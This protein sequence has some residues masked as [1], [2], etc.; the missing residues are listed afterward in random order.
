MSKFP[1]ARLPVGATPENWPDLIGGSVES[2]R[3]WLDLVWNRAELAESVALASPTLAG[4][5]QRILRGETA[6]P[7]AVRKATLSM[8]RYLLRE[9]GR[10]TPF[11]LF[12]GVAE[13]RFGQGAAVRWSDRH[14]LIVR[15]DGEWLASVIT[16][17]EGCP[18]LLVRL[19]VVANSLNQV[20]FD[21]LCLRRGQGHV[22]VPYTV[23]VRSALEAARSPI[24]AGALADVLA[25]QFVSVPRASVTSMI[26]CLVTEGFLVTCL[27]APSVIVNPL[28]YLL[29]RL[30]AVGADQVSAV[31]STLSGLHAIHSQVAMHNELDGASSRLVRAPLAVRMRDQA[32]TLRGP[33]ASDLRLDADLT[34]PESVG[35]EMEKAASVL[36]RL[37]A[38]PAGHE[39]WRD[40]LAAFLDRYGVGTLVPLT[41]LVHPDLGL[42]L[43]AGYPGSSFEPP[44]AAGPSERDRRLLALLHESTAEGSGEIVLSDGAVRDLAPAEVTAVRTPP[45]VELCARV[46][47]S[48]RTA[49]DT[50]DFTL[51]VRPARAAGTMTG[52]FIDDASEGLRGTIASVPMG[53]ADAVAAQ[54]SFPPAYPHAENIA[55]VPLFLDHVILLGEHQDPST[56][57]LIGIGDLAVTADWGRLRLVWISRHCPVE[58]QVF[59]ALRLEKQPPPLARFLAH[60]PRAFSAGY[61]AFDWGPAEEFRALP[62]VRYGRCVLSPAR[63]RVYATDL[64]PAGA[65]W[66]EWRAVLADWARRYRL[67]DTVELRDA[68]RTLRL[69]LTRDAHAAILR[70]HLGKTGDA[71]LTEADAIRDYGWLN[72]HAHE[73]AVPLTRRRPSAPSPLGARRRPLLDFA[74]HG[75][76]PAT[77]S[78]G[79][80]FAKLFIHPDLQS[81]L[82]VR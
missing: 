3:S 28:G 39:V 31:A 14:R 8:V 81:Q 16:R 72:G 46:L 27:R 40:Y 7:K 15:P 59:H 17:L 75:S 18:E 33:L 26:G 11:G 2:W 56:R 62:R 57:G 42:G 68:D 52:R 38:R 29:E 64:A 22:E 63:W 24:V 76:L 5:V 79:W 44:E 32:K 82:I 80:L 41:E 19:P 1:A 30:E 71:V 58:P 35:R 70:E 51:V 60:L 49:L 34:L 13:V 67:P 6:K 54:L 4:Q 10:P 61:T 37:T 23:A 78:G 25:E 50:G 55:R 74:T 36:L 69:D 65:V 48:S 21:R 53:D 77:P 20:R 45:H 73:I 43:P 12:A 9:S 66:T 47:A